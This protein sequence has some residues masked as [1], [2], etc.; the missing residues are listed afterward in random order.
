[1]EKKFFRYKSD[2][3]NKVGTFTMNEELNKYKGKIWAPKKLQEANRILRNLKHHYRSEFF[4]R[5]E[6]V[7]AVIL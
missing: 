4:N 6:L 3:F 1:M 5:A 7:Y 2:L